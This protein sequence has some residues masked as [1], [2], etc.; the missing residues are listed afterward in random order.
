[1]LPRTI[2]FAQETTDTTCAGAP[3]HRQGHQPSAICPV[4]IAISPTRTMLRELFDIRGLQEGEYAAEIP[5]LYLKCPPGDLSG[6]S[7]E[8]DAYRVR[9]FFAHHQGVEC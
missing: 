6:V 4:C 9:D 3:F 7:P 2:R 5:A 1:M 8:M